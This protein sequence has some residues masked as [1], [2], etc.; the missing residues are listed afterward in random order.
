MMERTRHR[1]SRRASELEE[2]S[3]FQQQKFAPRL[4]LDSRSHTSGSIR[5]HM[6]IPKSGQSSLGQATGISMKKLLAEEMSKEIESKRR[7]PNV[8]AKLMGLEGQPSPQHVYRQQKPSSDSCELKIALKNKHRHGKQNNCRSSKKSAMEQEEFRDVYEDVE[9]SHIVNRRCSSRWSASSIL[10]KPGMSLIQQKFIDAKRLSTDENLQNSK[11][12][13]GTIDQLDSNKELLLKYLQKPSSVFVKHLHDA[14]VDHFN[15]FGSHIAVLKPSCSEKY[16]GNAKAWK[17]ESD[18]FSNLVSN[19]HLKREDGLLLAPHNRHGAYISS[20]SPEIELQE[21]NETMILP[22]RIVVLKPNLGKMQN[23][24][25]S[26]SSRDPTHGY[27]PNFSKMKECSGVRGAKT[28]SW[29]SKDAPC[30]EEL[31]KMPMSK[32]AREIA[33]DITKRMRVSCDETMD[34][35]SSGFR[36][37]AGDESSYDAYG[38]DYESESD[39]FKLF[40]QSSLC[41][42]KWC[43]YP[44]PT[45]SE[46]SVN[47]EA[48]KRLSERWKVTHRYQDVEIV[49]KGSTL[50]EMLAISERE[51]RSKHS[52]ATASISGEGNLFGNSNGTDL[53]DNTVGIS[54]KDGWKNIVDGTSYRNRS[55]PPSMGGR[56]Y[57]SSTC[58]EKLAGEKHLMDGE[59]LRRGRSKVMKGNLS[60]IEKV[61]KDSKLLSKKHPLHRDLFI[62]EI[63]ASAEASFEIQMEANIKELSGQ[64]PMFQIQGEDEICES[65]V[66]DALTISDPGGTT[67]FSK[68]SDSLPK[69]SFSILDEDLSLARDQDDSTLQELQKRPPEQGS[70]SSHFLGTELDSS[71][72]SK[73]ADHPSPVSVLQ[74]PFAEDASSSSK[75]FERV[76]AELHELRMQLQLLKMQSSEYSEVS[77][78]PLEEEV[79]ELSPIV[80]GKNHV[81]ET[82]GWEVSYALDVLNNSS[83]EESNPGTVKKNHSPECPLDPGLFDDLE[84][85]YSDLTVGSRPERRL[86]FD[87]ISSAIFQVSQHQDGLLPWVMPKLGNLQMTRDKEGIRDNVVKLINQDFPSGDVSETVLDKEMLWSD[88]KQEVDLVG[89]EIEKLLIDDLISDIICI[90]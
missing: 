17:S 28:L 83:M 32:G 66:S 62:S 47:K 43:L 86:L 34:T 26:S 65:I 68:S 51:T 22:T 57:K 54:S 25:I 7:P 76:R 48:K 88:S 37:Y 84:K 39:K 71:E 87:T 16:E 23:A 13:D 60:R 8:I 9:A 85:K 1:K 40:H 75:S 73:E 11:E 52:N 61:S 55:I 2:I 30:N 69:Q 50:G 58:H 6:I 38:S 59:T 49:S 42:E 31:P 90:Y 74:V 45:L 63:N 72:S 79:S 20:S 46:S 3:Q 18:S 27:L 35:K 77:L 29:R 19:C 4:S 36:G 5:D 24:G 53:W 33:R 14:Q 44:S 21:K 56:S 15:S 67:S 41:D 12:L 78:I 89:S 82:E 80:Y 10:S 81:L 70:P 64:K